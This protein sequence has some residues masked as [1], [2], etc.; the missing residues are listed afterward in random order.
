MLKLRGWSGKAGKYISKKVPT[1]GLHLRGFAR[2][3][4]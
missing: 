2:S 4:E 1:G 3:A